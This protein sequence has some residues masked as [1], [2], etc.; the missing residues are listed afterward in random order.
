MRIL[1]W[2]GALMVIPAVA[3]ALSSLGHSVQIVDPKNSDW[4]LSPSTQVV[5]LAL[6]GEYGE[7]GT[8][9][10]HLEEMGMPYTG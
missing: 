10:K 4:K 1:R 2:S 6:H 8:V 9:Q 3:R 7:D 5:F